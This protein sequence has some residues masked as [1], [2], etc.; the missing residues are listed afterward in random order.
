[1][2]SRKAWG[3]NVDPFILVKFQKPTDIPDGENSIVSLVMFEWA[4][5]NLIGKPVSESPEELYE[6]SHGY[7]RSTCDS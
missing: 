5:H 3:G 1:M 7:T 4:D 2:Y 6:V